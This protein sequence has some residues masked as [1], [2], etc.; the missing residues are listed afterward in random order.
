MPDSA[1]VSVFSIGLFDA[2]TVTGSC[3]MPA[4]EPGA[5]GHLLGVGR[6]ARTDQVGGGLS[7]AI[8][9]DGEVVAVALDGCR[10]PPMSSERW[11]SCRSEH[12][13]RPRT[14]IAAMVAAVSVLR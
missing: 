6:A 7:T 2:A 12:A 5:V 3:A 4:T 1:W 9:A 14:A 10:S 11:S 13:E 8:G